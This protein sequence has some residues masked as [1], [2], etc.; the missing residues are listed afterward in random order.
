MTLK[1]IL[2]AFELEIGLLD[3]NINKPL[4]ADSMYWLDQALLKFIKL[5]F[6]R[7]FTH[8]TGFEQNEKR[9]RD[10]E[11]L[12]MNNEYLCKRNPSGII[13]P[14]HGFV[15][16]DD[17]LDAGVAQL[18]SIFFNSNTN[19]FVAKSNITN[20]YYNSW[21]TILDYHDEN[22]N[23]R[24]DVIFSYHP[25]GAFS[26]YYYFKDGK[27]HYVVEIPTEQETYDEYIIDVPEDL[28]YVLSESVLIDSLDGGHQ[29]L[30]S[31]FE[32]THD[33]YAYR[34]SNSLTDFHY[35]NYKARPLR[36]RFNGEIKLL[37]DKNYEIKKYIL[38]YIAKPYLFS[39]CWKDEGMDS[40]YEEINETAL[41]EIIKM[42]AQM[43]LEN[44]KD[45]RYKTITQ[46]VLTQ[47]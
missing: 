4:V 16:V 31:V 19:S 20:K 40:E 15:N 28:L 23:V 39:Q 11:K 9:F 29:K 2:K 24:E 30:V 37:T 41:P 14:F 12:V 43:Y 6:N 22:L 25:D 8:H 21:P 44:T 42:A 33:N 36:I 46:E 10:L 32:C 13:A 18:Y 1:D 35:K 5:R 26:G 3:D 7:D 17:V 34:I 47:E 45:D 38:S 27:M